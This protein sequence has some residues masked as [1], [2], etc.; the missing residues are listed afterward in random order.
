MKTVVKVVFGMAGLGWTALALAAATLVQD[1]R[2]F[3]GEKV[4]MRRSVL[5]ENGKIINVDFQGQAPAGTTLV[6]GAGKT[7]MPGLIDSHT[8]HFR[9]MELPV[10]FGVTTQLDMFSAV[11]LMQAN[12]RRM[13]EGASAKFADT[14]SSGIMITAPGGHGTQYGMP[15]PTLTRADDAQSFID[16]RI[17]EGSDYIKIV[18]EG[19]YGLKSLDE[20]TF[21]AAVKAAKARGKLAVV[22]VSTYDNARLALDAGAD[23]LVHLFTGAAISKGEVDTL[24]KLAKKANAFV[25]PTFSVMESMAGLK[26]EGILADSQ[27]MALLDKDQVKPLRATF[28]KALKPEILTAPKALTIAMQRAGVPVLA[29]TDAG[30]A[31]TQYGISMHHEMAALVGAG[32]TPVQALAAATSAPAKAFRLGQRGR[33][34]NGYKADLLLVEGDPTVD[35]NATRR[36][37]AVWK[38][39][40]DAAPLRNAQADKVAAELKALPPQ[41]LQLPADGRI[42]QFSKAKMGSP[43]GLGWMPTNDGFMGGKST[44][45]L[46]VTDEHPDA[47]SVNASVAPGFP[48][49]WAGL[50]FMPGQQPMAPVNL[51]NAKVLKFRVRGDGGQYNVAMMSKGVQIPAN[52]PFTAGAAWQEVSI[53]LAKFDRIDTTEVTMIGF[54]AGPKTGE[55]TFQITDVRLL[56]E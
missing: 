12:Q 23:G 50:A 44:V 5:I 25:I 35:I 22:H 49:P 1:V 37:V 43:V 27:L 28:G 30:N 31:G 6:N 32:L 13:K 18:L 47:V 15:I 42:S 56:N 8:H 51:S 9:F 52:V 48:M 3:D 55:Y 53:P 46:E 54:H 41:A 11:E 34:A 2:V 45:R 21:R 26:E 4:H 19:G 14:F 10:L 38:D 36:I 40:E 33:I 17:A 39:G 16:A 24:V 29:G 20:P 7:L